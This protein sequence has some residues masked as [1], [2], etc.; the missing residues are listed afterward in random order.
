[1]WVANGSAD[2]LGYGKRYLGI[3]T[4]ADKCDFSNSNNGALYCAVPDSLPEGSGLSRSVAA[5]SLYSIYKIDINTGF[6]EKIS[7]PVYNNQRVSI[8]KIYLDNNERK[9][10]Y[11]NESNGYLYSIDLQP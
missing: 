6:K 11:T 10:Y 3:N 7:E 8:D 9:L 4:W 5:G 1:L 2:E